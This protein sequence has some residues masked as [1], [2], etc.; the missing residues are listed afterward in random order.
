[1]S[2]PANTETI[3]N[4]SKLYAFSCNCSYGVFSPLKKAL[5]KS[6]FLIQHLEISICCLL[7]PLYVHQEIAILAVCF[8]PS[9]SP[10][11]PFDRLPTLPVPRKSNSLNFN[12]L[13]YRTTKTQNQTSSCSLFLFCCF[14]PSL[15]FSVA[16]ETD[17]GL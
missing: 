16:S 2:K 13:N 6:A 14:L 7:T 9:A 15:S 4:S 5:I 8:Q 3:E 17:T 12:L 1:M 11:I 10:S